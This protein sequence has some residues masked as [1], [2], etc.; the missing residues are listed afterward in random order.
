MIEK[1]DL[2]KHTESFGQYSK[3]FILHSETTK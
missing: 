2:E 1:A 3:P